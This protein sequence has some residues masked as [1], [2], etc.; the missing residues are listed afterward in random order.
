M[1]SGTG[2]VDMN[3]CYR[4]QQP[5]H[6]RYAIDIYQATYSKAALSAD[7]I[8][9]EARKWRADLIGMGTH[10]RRDI[11]HM[12]LGSDAEAG[13][14]SSPVPALLVRGKNETRK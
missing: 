3:Q 8:L 11:S 1:L 7:V 9:D 4:L 6:L 10:G 13:V 5:S 2:Y 12:L 14:R